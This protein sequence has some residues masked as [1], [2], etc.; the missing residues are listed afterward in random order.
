MLR[1]P[2]C[3][4]LV[5]LSAAAAFSACGGEEESGSASPQPKATAA[6][7]AATVT[8]KTF[9]YK[10]NP[11]TVK[12]G[13]TV[14]FTNLDGTIHTITAGTREKPT[15]ELFDGQLDPAS[16][17]FEFTFDKA[18]TY[19]YYCTKHAGMSGKVIVS[20]S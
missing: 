9:I 14:T 17:K 3:A 19:E 12:A 6:A 5:T 4:A 8:T 11:I 2:L 20:G 16:G 10:P 1:R 18:G 7:D 13:T 15:P